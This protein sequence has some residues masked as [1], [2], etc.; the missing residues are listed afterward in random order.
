MNAIYLTEEA[1]MKYEEWWFVFARKKNN[2]KTKTA[3][4][5][6]DVNGLLPFSS[7]IV[8]HNTAAKWISC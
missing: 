8:E 4:I 3:C 7:R 2:K 5:E 1:A 6:N